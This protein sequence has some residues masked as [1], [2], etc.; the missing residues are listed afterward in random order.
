MLIVTVFHRYLYRPSVQSLHEFFVLVFSP[1]SDNL[2]RIRER[3]R[4]I[5]QRWSMEF[6]QEST[7]AAFFGFVLSFLIARIVFFSVSNSAADFNSAPSSA[8]EGAAANEAT[9]ERELTA[10]RRKREKRVKFVDDVVIRRIDR[11]EGS[12]N[13][14][15]FDDVKE[16]VEEIVGRK[17]ADEESGQRVDQFR[18]D[19]GPCGDFRERNSKDESSFQGEMDGEKTEMLFEKEGDGAVG[20]NVDGLAT[21]G[22]KEEVGLEEEDEVFEERERDGENEEIVGGDVVEEKKVR[23]DSIDDDDWEGVERS[24]L[25][26]EFAEAVNYVECGGKGKVDDGLAKLGCDVQMQLYGLHKVALEGPC[27]EPQPMAFMVSASAKWYSI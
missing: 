22:A 11:Y 19:E 26:K 8:S 25:E 18:G 20:Q 6:L 16:V 14:A 21:S 23:D 3:E 10:R 1:S 5:D 17:N 27:L 15:L 24:E 7:F 2:S 12:E 9:L 13:L 4:E